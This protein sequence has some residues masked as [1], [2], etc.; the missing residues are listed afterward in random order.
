MHT[1]D[2]P[3]FLPY[4]AWTDDLV[5]ELVGE[6]TDADRRRLH[7]MLRT[8]GLSEWRAWLRDHAA[9]AARYLGATPAQRRKA[10]NRSAY[11]TLLLEAYGA[12][13]LAQFGG[14]M[15]S[16]FHDPSLTPDWGDLRRTQAARGR[17]IWEGWFA[18]VE[19]WPFD[20]PY[21]LGDPFD[22]Q[23]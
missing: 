19:P 11:E 16:W 20:E 15:A 23:S 14:A 17:V 6:L 12:L 18:T 10:R 9:E 4:S 8:L 21:D 7:A 13:W 2:T 3:G 22:D 1:P 5:R